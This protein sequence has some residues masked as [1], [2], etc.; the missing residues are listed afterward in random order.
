MKTSKSTQPPP[1][2]SRIL[3]LVVGLTAVGFGGYLILNTLNNGDQTV[4]R[5]AGGSTYVIEVADEDDERYQGLSDR[6]SIGEREGMLFVYDSPANYF[7][8]MRGMRFPLDFIWI[9]SDKTIIEITKDIEPAT[10]PEQ[11]FSSREPSQYILE[12]NA[13]T[14]VREGWSVGDKVEFNVD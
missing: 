1:R 14:A 13:G 12:V 8:V 11:V 4:F 2:K 10:Y 7:F 5:V 3:S 9:D 6:D